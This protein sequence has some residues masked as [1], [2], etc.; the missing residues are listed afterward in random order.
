MALLGD[1]I[2]YDILKTGVNRSAN[3]FAALALIGKISA[4]FGS[5]LGFIIIGAFGY[6]VAGPNSDFANDGL[7]FTALIL[8]AIT[9]VM[10]G[11]I[12]WFFPIDH[13]RHSI[14]RRRIEARAA[15]AE[16]AGL[17]LE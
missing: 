5:G 14:I 10:G 8:P 12:Y 17:L 2:D 4:A 13:R 11:F 16:R 3:Y 15:R 6:T 9:G 7:K 1:V